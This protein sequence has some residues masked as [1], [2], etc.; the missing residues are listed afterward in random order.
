MDEMDDLLSS[1]RLEAGEMLEDAEARLL[2]VEKGDNLALHFDAIF[3]AFHSIKGGAGVFEMKDLQALVHEGET[4]F[5]AF[6]KAA[7]MPEEDLAFF[8]KM[9]D[10]ARVG[11]NG[12][13][14]SMTSPT[15]AAPVKPISSVVTEKTKADIQAKISDHELVAVSIDD[16]QDIVDIIK[17]ILQPSGFTVH[18]FTDPKKAVE[19]LFNLKPDVV[20]CDMNMPGMTG[21]DVLKVIH[22]K[23]PSIPL[24]FVSAHLDKDVL[25]S[26]INQGADAVAEKPFE[27]DYILKVARAA[28]RRHRVQ[29][30]FDQ[31]VNLMLYQ[32]SDFDDYLKATGRE[33]VREVFEKE[34]GQLIEQRRMLR[35]LNKRED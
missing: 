19:E 33:D 10:Q 20:L 25:M 27:N 24:I 34:M 16:E 22:K 18:T 31:T 1:F 21:L 5:T 15:A 35:E 32:Y 11:L 26:A 30:L 9:L 3:R 8:M 29:K 14:I 6:K 23:D 4:K 17:D 13:K 28:G 12:G 7:S 2:K